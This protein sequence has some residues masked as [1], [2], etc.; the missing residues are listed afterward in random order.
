MNEWFVA[1]FLFSEIKIW[2]F[3]NE[4]VNVLHIHGCKSLF[5][6]K[7]LLNIIIPMLTKFIARVKL[8]LQV[9]IVSTCF[10]NTRQSKTQKSSKTLI[11]AEG[12]PFYEGCCHHQWRDII[13]SWRGDS[14][15]NG[16]G[17]TGWGGD[18]LANGR[19]ETDW[20]G[21]CRQCLWRYMEKKENIIGFRGPL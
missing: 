11:F 19:G 5:I 8:F 15:A 13:D 21:W 20:C 18:S 16:R 1:L 7:C 2:I 12:I 14:L 4:F 6:L 17:E 10:I 3:I 9:Q